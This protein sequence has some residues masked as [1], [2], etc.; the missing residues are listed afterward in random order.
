[1]ESGV[2]PTSPHSGIL[3]LC[4]AKGRS[5]KKL[6]PLLTLS[7]MFSVLAFADTFSGKLIDEGCYAKQQSAA[8][9]DAT[10]ATKTFALDV[11][12][13]IYRLDAM[14]NEKASAAL[15]NRAD[16]SADPVKSLA[17]GIMA[18]VEGTEHD[19]QLKVTSLE[20]Q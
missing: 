8:G 7:M 16:Q 12:G 10:S 19:G 3:W 4:D 11:A 14:G 18:K 2:Q 1:M 13:K 5:M 6:L 9:C 17:V 15:K 20:V